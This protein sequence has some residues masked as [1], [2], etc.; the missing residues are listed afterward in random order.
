VTSGN[1]EQYEIWVDNHGKWELVALFRSVKV[2][3]AVFATRSY[4]QKLLHVTYDAAGKK[5]AEDTVAEIGRTREQEHPVE[6]MPA[7][8][9]EPK[10]R[11]AS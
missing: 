1:H 11:K 10:K 5:L 7:A 2:A 9:P 8:K 4:R 6:E 3:S